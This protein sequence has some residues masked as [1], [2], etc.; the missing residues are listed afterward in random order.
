MGFRR[1]THRVAAVDRLARWAWRSRAL[2][3]TNSH[4]RT[5]RCA[6]SSIVRAL[7][8]NPIRDRSPTRARFRNSVLTWK[9]STHCCS[10]TP[11]C[12]TERP[13]QGRT[14]A[15]PRL[16]ARGQPADGTRTRMRN[17]AP[18]T[19]SMVIE[20]MASRE[21]W[22]SRAQCRLLADREAAAL[23]FEGALGAHVAT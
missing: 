17:A 14:G 20:R 15:S 2:A 3:R 11:S 19:N 6:R 10:A 9:P 12:V 1:G 4:G 21:S 7:P 22:V 5:P 13:E 23:R 8:G 18:I 16:R